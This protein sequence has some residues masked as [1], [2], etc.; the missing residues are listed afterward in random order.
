M[1]LEESKGNFNQIL[2][3]ALIS[4]FGDSAFYSFD[5]QQATVITENNL[6]YYRE[7]DLYGTNNHYY[8]GTTPAFFWKLDIVT[9]LEGTYIRFKSRKRG[10]VFLSLLLFS[11]V[12][13][14]AGLLVFSGAIDSELREV[15]GGSDFKMTQVLTVALFTIPSFII[16]NRIVNRTIFNA[17][18]LLNKEKRQDHSI[19]DLRFLLKKTIVEVFPLSSI[20]TEDTKSFC[21]KLWG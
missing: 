12:A 8:K 21:Y 5:T 14:T 4:R 18:F 3:E 13:L 20:E 6:A 11:V 17:L 19:A 10:S 9:T 1:E 7:L 15:F 16:I 2:Q